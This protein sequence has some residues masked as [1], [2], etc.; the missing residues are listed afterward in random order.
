M[1]ADLPQS[2]GSWFYS[3]KDETEAQRGQVPW[4][5]S[6]SREVPGIGTVCGPTTVLCAQ[7][8]GTCDQYLHW[9]VVT[10]PD[11]VGTVEEAGPLSFLGSRSRAQRHMAA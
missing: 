6:H 2:P 11:L 3:I 4:P 8:A 5:K 7:A 10:T 9:P 1:Q